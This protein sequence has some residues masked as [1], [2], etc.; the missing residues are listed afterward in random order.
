M[1]KPLAALLQEVNPAE[2]EVILA[3]TLS[4]EEQQRLRSAL[5][6][7]RTEAAPAQ[8]ITTA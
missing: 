6:N 4:S 2:L 3:N 1:A 8:E 7:A 5:E